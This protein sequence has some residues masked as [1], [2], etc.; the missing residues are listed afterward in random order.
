MMTRNACS[1]FQMGYVTPDML[2][3]LSVVPAR[4]NPFSNASNTIPSTFVP[5]APAF[6]TPQ[7]AS[8]MEK[9]MLERLRT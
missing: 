1:K 3:I 2:K 7:T 9:L 8:D 4:S 5:T 6:A